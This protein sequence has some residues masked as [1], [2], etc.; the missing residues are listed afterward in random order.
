MPRVEF[1]PT[2]P[3]LERAKTLRALGRGDISDSSFEQ[4][5]KTAINSTEK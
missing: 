3:V 5:Q 2:I 1:E 4:E